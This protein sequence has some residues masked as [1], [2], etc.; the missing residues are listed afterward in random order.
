MHLLLVNP[1]LVAG[2][3]EVNL[4]AIRAQLAPLRG[5]LGPND[6]AL[7]PEHHY[8]GPWEAYLDA[9]REL[10]QWLG[11]TL[12]GGSTHR[13]LEAT[14]VNSGAVFSANGELL[15]LFDKLR[16]YANERQHVAPGQTRGHFSIAGRRV[17]V[18]ICADFWFTDLLVAEPLPDLVLVPAL[19][20]TRKPT[21][22][23]SRSLWRHTAVARAYEY[24]VYVGISDWASDSELPALHTSGVSGFADPTPSDPEQLFRHIDEPALIELDFSRLDAFR[25]DR[26]ARGFFW[27]GPSAAGSAHS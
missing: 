25:A 1:R 13:Q 2:A 27:G 16:P 22:E 23:Y 8:F 17:S 11:C 5:A 19:S 15:T 18:L 6:L 3:S 4:A 9:M 12:V 20:V 14:R 21:P 7:L 10:A 24:G 26:R